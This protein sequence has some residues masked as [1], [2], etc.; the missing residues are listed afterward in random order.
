MSEI[1]HTKVLII[2]A[3]PAGYTAAIYAARASLGPMLVAGLTPGGQLTITTDV[4]NYPGFA[5]TIQGPWL[6]E[7]MQA[8]AEHVGTKIVYDMI[9]GVDFSRRPFRCQGDSG[10]V[11]IADSVIIATGAQ[12]RWLGLESE[13]LLQ[14]R[15]VSACATCDGFFYRGRTVAVIGGGNTAVEEALYLT[16]HA[17]KVILIHRRDSFRAEKI[18]QTRLFANPKIEVRW[19]E[20]VAEVLGG[21]SPEVVTGLRLTNTVTGTESTLPVDGVFIAIGHTPSTEVFAGHVDLDNDGFIRTIPGSTRTSVPGVFAAGDVQDKI[22]RQAVTAAG[23]GC[24]AAL[25]AEKYL[26]EAAIEPSMAAE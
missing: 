18:L 20:R 8:Q 12:A 4:E 15:G 26:A 1:H 22:F 13:Q 23:T 5:E 11:Y 16:H 7:Q 9:T 3:G 2:G 14:G 19:N 10:D 25:E 17:D 6:M 24:M 21:G